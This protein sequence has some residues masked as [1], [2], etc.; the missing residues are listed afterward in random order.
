[1]PYKETEFGKFVQF[2]PLTLCPIDTSPIEM[3]LL[4]PVEKAWLNNYHQHVRS[5]LLPLLSEKD[6]AEWLIDAT[7]EI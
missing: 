4:T 2:E 3:S 7:K 6:D 1:V 5:R